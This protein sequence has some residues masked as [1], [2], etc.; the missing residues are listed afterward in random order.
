VGGDHHPVLDCR[1]NL[2]NSTAMEGCCI[3]V[4]TKMTILGMMDDL[5]ALPVGAQS[6]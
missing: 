4:G 5:A 3:S 6:G 2:S 1:E